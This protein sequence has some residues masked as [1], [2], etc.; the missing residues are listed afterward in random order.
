MWKA[1]I[2]FI[3]AAAVFTLAAYLILHTLRADFRTFMG[4]VI[5]FLI[6]FAVAYFVGHPEAWNNVIDFCRNLL[7][8]GDLCGIIK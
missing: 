2:F 6:G 8:G 4:G 5:L 7:T 1:I 3:L